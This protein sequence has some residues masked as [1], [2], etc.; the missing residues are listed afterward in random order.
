MMKTLMFLALV[1][2]AALVPLDLRAQPFSIPW[3][4]VDGG[5]GTSTGGGFAVSGTVGQPDA[6]RASGG[7]FSI[8][9]G[10]W[11]FAA[12]VQ[13]TGPL[14]EIFN[15]ATN[16]IVVRWPYPSTGF[17]LQENSDVTTTNWT[18]VATVPSDDGIW[19][20]VVVTPPVGPKYYRL[21]K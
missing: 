11:G 21:R 10:F 13:E 20:W 18:D 5:G 6:G 1:A 4:T 2:A 7:D 17:I 19:K 3:S 14:L 8:Q 15:T 16:A 12:A 9:G